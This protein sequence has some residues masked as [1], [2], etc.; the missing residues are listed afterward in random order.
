MLARRI[1]RVRVLQSQAGSRM[2]ERVAVREF[3][4]V[5]GRTW[6]AWEIQPEAIHPQTRA[7][8]YLADCYETGWV[9]FETADG[10]EKRRLCPYPRAWSTLSDA[11]L[12]RLIDRAEIVPPVKHAQQRTTGGPAAT[13]PS[14]RRGGDDVRATASTRP[15]DLTDLGV[16]RSFRYPRGRLWSVCV[17]QRPESGGA[18]VL[19]FTAG[20][21]SIDLRQWPRDWPDYPDDR[22]V[23]L[24]RLA[25]PRRPSAVAPA[26]TP[27]RRYTDQRT[28]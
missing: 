8:D 2:E 23:E 9:V 4:D 13:G 15:A 25:S 11:D 27:P 22:L 16:V 19:R 1:P 6:R 20:A 10:R 26:G 17:V 5:A 3:V 18:A 12:T 7:E 14:P 28:D 21:R 24:L